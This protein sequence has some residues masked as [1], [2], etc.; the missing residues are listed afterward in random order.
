MKPNLNFLGKLDFIGLFLLRFGLGG[1]IA[2]HGYPSLIGGSDVWKQTGRGINALNI[3]EL[4]PNVYLALGI[5]SALIQV[6]GGAAVIIGFYTRASALLVSIVIAFAIANMFQ[7][8]DTLLHAIFG[9][10]LGL[11]FLGLA[12][13]GPGRLSL[14][15]KGL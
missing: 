6:L 11:A 5:C 14:D 2:F 10:Q 15:R 12:F 1:T 8:G 13:I 7:N 4:D 3:V 9:A